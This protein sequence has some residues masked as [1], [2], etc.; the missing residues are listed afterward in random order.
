MCIKRQSFDELL[1]E[2]MS[3][4]D[5]TSV[6]HTSQC[7]ERCTDIELRE[8]LVKAHQV[9]SNSNKRLLKLQLPC[10]TGK[11]YIMLYTMLECLKTKP[12]AKFCVFCPWV[13]LA[14][15]LRDLLST[16]LH[17]LFIGGGKQ[18]RTPPGSQQHQVV[19]CV[20][21]SAHH[22]PEDDHYEKNF[23]DEAHHLRDENAAVR[24]RLDKVPCA[25]T[26]MLSATF[27]ESEDLD[28]DFSM[29]EAIDGG[30]ISDYVLHL[31]FFSSGDRTCGLRRMLVEHSEWFP[32]FVY[33]NSTKR[34]IECSKYLQSQGV[35]CDHLVG[36]DGAEKRRLIR[37]QL[38]TG[39]LNVLCLCGC[40]NEG[41]SID[42]IQ[43]VVFGDLRHSQINKI[44]IAMRANR[45]HPTKPFSRIVW[46][47]VQKDLDNKDVRELVQS[48]ARIDSAVQEVFRNKDRQSSRIRVHISQDANTTPLSESQ[49]EFLYE[50]IYS[51]CCN[52]VGGWGYEEQFDMFKKYVVENNK[53]PPKNKKLDNGWAI[54]EW[55]DK[56]KSKIKSKEDGLYKQ[57]ADV[58]KVV[59][60]SLDKLL[61]KRQK[62]KPNNSK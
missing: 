17:V 29:R 23:Y 8:Y 43:T 55:Y 56:Q 38:E 40:Y 34:C 13:D 39:K 42:N 22:I 9:I 61:Q 21:G 46:P 44:Q 53:V 48:F 4:F 10:G 12:S 47:L 1:A 20:N 32:M 50:Q 30:Y 2:A 7:E 27:H 35:V 15:Q 24:S 6:L 37:Y 36:A 54:G 49:A 57:F 58:H 45:K 5:I 18:E 52:L 14:K 33:F 19:V 26:V 51:R 28:Y 3:G 62:R 25:Q 41:I 31:E 60:A 16:H 11:S 59:R